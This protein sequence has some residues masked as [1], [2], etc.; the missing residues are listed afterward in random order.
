[1][2]NDVK[3]GIRVNPTGLPGEDTYSAYG[4][5]C[6]L[7]EPELTELYR[8]L[9]A[10][11]N[12]LEEVTDPASEGFC[13]I[14]SL[15]LLG[16]MLNWCNQELGIM[17]DCRYFDGFVE[18]LQDI[19]FEIGTLDKHHARDIYGMKT[20]IGYKPLLEKHIEEVWNRVM[21]V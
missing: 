17:Y 5:K 7:T 16:D 11:R 10:S 20:L 4:E 15:E 12:L 9:V 19:D 2:N 8:K 14:S 13:N 21:S 6:T 1:M 3:H 18:V